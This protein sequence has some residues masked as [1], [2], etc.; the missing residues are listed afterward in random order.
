MENKQMVIR[1]LPIPP[2]DEEFKINVLLWRSVVDQLIF[3]YL[4][5]S[6]YDAAITAREEATAYLIEDESELE[7]VCDLAQIDS[8]QVANAIRFLINKGTPS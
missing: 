6:T 3:D 5:D 8:I 4:N 1:L 2:G 7:I